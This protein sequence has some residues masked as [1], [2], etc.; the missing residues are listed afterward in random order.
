M[1]T[2]NNE[3]SGK[4]WI[5]VL[6]KWIS[7]FVIGILCGVYFK[8]HLGD[9]KSPSTPT[10]KVAPSKATNKSTNEKASTGQTAATQQSQQSK[11]DVATPAQEQ[12]SNSKQVESETMIEEPVAKTTVT[13]PNEEAYLSL[14]EFLKKKGKSLRLKE[15]R[16]KASGEEASVISTM[17]K[18]QGTKFYTMGLEDIKENCSKYASEYR[19]NGKYFASDADFYEAYISADYS[20]ILK[21][22]KKAAK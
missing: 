7:I 8:T 13:N 16:K 2:N 1:A 15:A 19:K 14:S 12:T 6:V 18:L 17:D 20:M 10:E 4:R 11:E 3:K 5:W 9:E 22:N 21:E